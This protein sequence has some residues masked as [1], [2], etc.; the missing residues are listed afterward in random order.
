VSAFGLG[1][2]NFHVVVA[3]HAP[4]AGASAGDARFPLIDRHERAGADAHRFTRPVSMARDRYLHDHLVGGV[5]VVPGAFGCELIAEAAS[6]AVPGWHVVG[7]EDVQ[8]LQLL[9]VPPD[10][11]VELD[12][13]ARCAAPRDGRAVVEVD[14]GSW[15]SPR[16]ARQRLRR[17]H[18]QGR[19]ILAERVPPARMVAPALLDAV[20]AWQGRDYAPLYEK[21]VYSTLGPRFRAVREARVLDHETILARLETPSDDDLFAG[22]R[23]PRLVLGPIMV[24]NYFQVAGTI[25][26]HHNR[27][28]PLP[29]GVTR[30]QLWNR[31]VAGDTVW[32]HSRIGRDDGESLWYGITV[33]DGLGRIYAQMD[34]MQTRNFL[35]FE[36]PD[37]AHFYQT[38]VGHLP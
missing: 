36:G 10:E 8:F 6:Q 33:F 38:L 34:D 11:S 14:V 18:F 16:G 12:V 9:R 28:F 37:L 3:E 26:V 7:L 29:V 32:V 24:D 20:R 35:P 23:Q 17:R 1:G 25:G 5:P 31:A 19:A 15:F 30:I 13:Q 4:A 21:H 2:T 27:Q 22:D